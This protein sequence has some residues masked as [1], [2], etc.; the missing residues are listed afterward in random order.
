MGEYTFWDEM[1]NVP[2]KSEDELNKEENTAQEQQFLSRKSS[3]G[4]PIIQ[5][6]NWGYNSPKVPKKS[7]FGEIQQLYSP[8]K[9]TKKS[10]VRYNIVQIED[11]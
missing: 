9:L 11:K 6:L 5:S 7:R 1:W 10:L 4:E 8:P 3:L 2:P